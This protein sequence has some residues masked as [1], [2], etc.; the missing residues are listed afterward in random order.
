MQQEKYIN[1]LEKKVKALEEEKEKLER[2]TVLYK[3]LFS[4]LP[5]GVKIYQP[6]GKISYKNE[7]A[8]K[9]LNIPDKKTVDLFNGDLPQIPDAEH[10]YKKAFEGERVN[11]RFHVQ[12]NGQV[13]QAIC[14]DE[15]IF[16]IKDKVQNREYGVSVSTDCTEAYKNVSRLKEIKGTFL[17]VFEF[18]KTINIVSGFENE[19][20]YS[21]NRAAKDFY[22]YE[23]D[24]LK[25]QSLR[26]LFHKSDYDKIRTAGEEAVCN[27]KNLFHFSHILKNGAE[28]EVEA[29]ITPIQFKGEQRLFW[30]IFDITEKKKAL[31][32]LKES[33]NRLQI[34]GSIAYDL[35]YEWDIATNRLT[36]F[37]G[38]NRKL[39]YP[40]GTIKNDIESWISIIHPED[41][42]KLSNAV[43]LHR[44]STDDI[45]YE[46][47]MKHGDGTWHYWKDH[48]KAVLDDH[49]KAY[50]WIG[51]CTNIS[52]EKEALKKLRE[53]EADYRLLAE[54]S[55]DIIAVFENLKPVFVS[56][57]AEKILGYKP[58]DFLKTSPL[59]FIHPED[60]KGVAAEMERRVVQETAETTTYT[61]RQKHKNGGWRWLETRETFKQLKPGR[62]I[63]IL[64]SRDITERMYA[65]QDIKKSE[66][67]FK[68]I[69]EQASA[70]IAVSNER[71]DIRDLNGKFSEILGYTKSEL[72]KM[73]VI[74]ITPKEDFEREYLMHQDVFAGKKDELCYE[75]R[76][77]HK[78]GH[79]VWANLSSNV[80]RNDKGEIEYIIA[81]IVD[82][83]AQKK[84]EK[85]LK[86]L[87][88]TK[89]K[90]FSII[91]HD[92]RSPF[93][94]ILGYS[95]LMLDKHHKYSS[96]KLRMMLEQLNLAAEKSYNLTENL[97]T[98][99]KSQ[100]GNYSPEPEK[101]AAL[102]AVNEVAKQVLPQ[103]KAKK[104]ELLLP[105][106]SYCIF[107]DSDFFQVIIRNLLTN[108]VKFTAEGGTVSLLFEKTDK[109]VKII[110]E[111]TGVGISE[112]KFETLFKVKKSK[113]TKGTNNESGTGLG[114][115]IC[116]EFT[117]QMN[118]T[119]KA[120]AKQTEG[121]R[122][123][124]ELP[125]C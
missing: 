51:V 53:S 2:E 110:V 66:A 105:Q 34:A 54:H 90:L 95:K 122:F 4:S 60:A 30:V 46:Y 41:R 96:E 22:G 78:K 120:E 77:I 18:N 13:K 98:W 125:A 74:D 57:S 11:R 43:E 71:G 84:A 5:V 24:E 29:Y 63:T 3:E 62:V 106:N 6:D 40:Q 112:D 79:F 92:L 16:G 99:A 48:G 37:G 23:K 88:E 121:S 85:K 44:T 86:E 111:D 10:F 1:F 64:N 69:F 107:A 94:A 124:V 115:L 42:E 56:K 117:E 87:N 39:G 109:N 26:K 81:V 31:A 108:A 101:I 70:G 104:I 72:L 47:R 68:S 97:L 102:Q 113:S 17:N 61:Y 38:I 75:K 7:F 100:V 83:T 89:D 28:R 52:K 116:K 73:S 50:K 15:H 19:K 45:R 20:I 80:V 35:I 119:I 65:M 21:I 59:D 9:L 49:G 36:W 118:G 55:S 25:E 14:I 8:Q 91:S 12:K 82:I 76:Y 103:A 114:L 33:E 27:K 93:N 67:K 58:E 32:A 123:I